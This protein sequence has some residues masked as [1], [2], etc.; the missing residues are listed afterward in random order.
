MHETHVRLTRFAQEPGVGANAAVRDLAQLFE[1]ARTASSHPWPVPAD[2]QSGLSAGDV[3]RWS[4]NTA[5]TL[6]AAQ[7]FFLPMVDDPF[8][9]GRI[10]ATGAL[11]PV[12]ASGA[13]PLFAFASMGMPGGVFP[14]AFIARIVA[15]Q[16]AGFRAVGAVVTGGRSFTSAVPMLGF[17]A[18]GVARPDRIRDA[19]GARPG[20]AIVLAK[21][22]GTG[23]YTAALARQ[24]LDAAAYRD[25]VERAVQANAAG[26]AL[27]A[28]GN[29]HA[30]AE[31]SE[32]GLAGRL[33]AMCRAASLSARI[34]VHTIPRLPQALALAKGGCIAR[35][36]A[37]NWNRDGAAIRLHDAVMPESRALVTDPQASGGLLVA[38]KPTS[39]D[40]IVTLLRDAGF[41]EAAEIGRF[42]E[43]PPQDADRIASPWLEVAS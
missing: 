13:T 15:G 20:D 6:V 35:A 17:V 23:I 43:A 32:T 3:T 34:A 30:L 28:I 9:F 25:F 1:S 36:S 26:P 31:V 16:E 11:S 38:C 27:A 21:P 40:R 24:K 41:A 7:T 10:A 5:Q 29:V 39:A 18:I 33:L 12:F 2:L 14:E 22:L 42:G 8:D 19:R 4:L 37:H